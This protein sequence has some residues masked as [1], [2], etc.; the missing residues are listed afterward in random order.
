M[1]LLTYPLSIISPIAWQK[2]VFEQT[3]LLMSAIVHVE[4]EG[5]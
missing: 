5:K 1:V 2:F 4:E 3:F